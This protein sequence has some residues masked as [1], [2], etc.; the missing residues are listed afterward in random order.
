MQGGY[1]LNEL[2]SLRILPAGMRPKKA[3]FA[4]NLLFLPPLFF[5]GNERLIKLYSDWFLE[6]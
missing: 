6:G 5:D 1:F 2:W 4:K 3:F